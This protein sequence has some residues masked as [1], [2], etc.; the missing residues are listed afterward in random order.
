ML[1]IVVVMI[2][3]DGLISPPFSYPPHSYYLPTYLPTYL[4]CS[5]DLWVAILVES[6]E[7]NAVEVTVQRDIHLEMMMMMII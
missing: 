3:D 1:M 5:F 6:I 2:I 4:S 7:E